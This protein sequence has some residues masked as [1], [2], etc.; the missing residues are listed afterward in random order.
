[1]IH[2]FQSGTDGATPGSPPIFVGNTLYGTAATGGGNPSCGGAPLN[3]GCGTVYKLTP[4]AGGYS[5]RSIYKF[6]GEPR[7]GANP[8]GGLAFDKLSSTFYGITQYGGSAN[9]GSVFSV[10]AAGSKEKVLHSFTGGTDGSYPTDGP[11]RSGHSLFGTTEYG[12]S[13][14]RNAGIAFE[15]TPSGAKYTEKILYVFQTPAQGEYPIGGLLVGGKSL[16]YG[17]TT[18]GGSASAAAGTV[19]SLTY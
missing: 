8:F 4:R 7:D 16:L 18:Y 3:R 6:T 9:Q 1:V 2:S 11:V 12:G 5:F 13:S 10:T 15:L 17:T 14:S 19:Y